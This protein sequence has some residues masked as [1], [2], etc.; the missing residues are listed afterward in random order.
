MCASGKT[1]TEN[2]VALGD[3][4]IVS[5]LFKHHFGKSRNIPIVRT[6]N[7]AAL[8]EERIKTKMFGEIS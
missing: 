1:F 5:G 4:V 8:S 6:G 7:L 3:E 2:E